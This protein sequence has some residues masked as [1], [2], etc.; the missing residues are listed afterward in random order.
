ME[1]DETVDV[2]DQ[3]TCQQHCARGVLGIHPR[4]AVRAEVSSHIFVSAQSFLHPA[5]PSYMDF[6]DIS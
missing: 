3:R 2:V 6:H 5:N 1:C 4:E